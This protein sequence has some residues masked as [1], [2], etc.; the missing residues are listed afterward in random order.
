MVFVQKRENDISVTRLLTNVSSCGIIRE[1]RRARSDDE[2]HAGPLDGSESVVNRGDEIA[3]DKVQHR[4]ALLGHDVGDVAHVQAAGVPAPVPAVV[5]AHLVGLREAGLRIVVVEGVAVVRGEADDALLRRDEDGLVVVEGLGIGRV[6]QELVPLGDVVGIGSVEHGQLH[7]AGAPGL[8]VRVLTQAE[9][10]AVTPGMHVPGEAGDLQSAHDLRVRGIGQV[11]GKEGIHL[12]EGDEVAH[13][14]VK[15]DGIDLLVRSHVGDGAG[16]VHIAVK[17]P[18]GVGL[19]GFQILVVGEVPRLVPPDLVAVVP[20]GGHHPEAAVVFVHGELIQEIA[21]HGA[22]GFDP[23]RVGHIQFKDLGAVAAGVFLHVVDALVEF[24]PLVVEIAAVRQIEIVFAHVESVPRPEDAEGILHLMPGHVVAA[25]H[26]IAGVL[27]GLWPADAVRLNGHGDASAV[28]GGHVV[29]GILLHEAVPTVVV[30]IGDEVE[31]SVHEPAGLV[32]AVLAL[33]IEKDGI[34]PVGDVVEVRQHVG[35]V[36]VPPLPVHLS[37]GVFAAVGEDHRGVA[38]DEHLRRVLPAAVVGLFRVGPVPGT[39]VVQGICSVPGGGAG[40]Q[41]S[42]G[43]GGGVDAE[44]VVEEG[45]DVR[46]VGLDDVRLVDALDLGVGLGVVPGRGSGLG[47]H[48]LFLHRREAV[49]RGHGSGSLHRLLRHG[50]LH[51]HAVR[52]RPSPAAI[53]VVGGQLFIHLGIGGRCDDG[54]RLRHGGQVRSA[55]IRGFGLCGIRFGG[56][57]LCRLDDGGLGG[58]VRVLRSAGDGSIA[59]GQQE[60]GQEKGGHALHGFHR[61]HSFQILRFRLSVH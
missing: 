32:V 39:L 44:L 28:Q 61:S 16:E 27:G 29:G 54:D 51:H 46:A 40:D 49:V 56:I 11:H 59:G 6:Q 22:G 38:Q 55:G 15:A 53:A 25:H 5:E 3:G 12:A 21:V 34:R 37:A 24:V 20:G 30:F 17:H 41:G 1:D 33:G 50:V 43:S 58:F 14:P 36:L 42:I 19:A 47:G 45:V 31:L 18:E 23:D 9:Q 10:Q 60:R 35:L 8:L 57:G 48:G 7:A 13:F 4:D 26:G 52:V 2:R